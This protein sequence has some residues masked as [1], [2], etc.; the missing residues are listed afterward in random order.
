ML[1]EANSSRSCCTP[2]VS[3]PGGS[4]WSRGHRLMLRDIWGGAGNGAPYQCGRV[5]YTF[6]LQGPCQG[7][8]TACSSSLVATHNA[9]RGELFFH[10]IFNYMNRTRQCKA[11]QCAHLVGKNRQVCC[12]VM[13]AS[14]C[15]SGTS[16]D[17]CN[18]SM[19]T[20]CALNCN[21]LSLLS[22]WFLRALE[23]DSEHAHEIPP[24]EHMTYPMAPGTMR[25]CSTSAC[26]LLILRQNFRIS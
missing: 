4:M 7:I 26:S 23:R 22:G 17:P 5:A 19:A 12:T 2:S 6:G 10:R 16:K 21:A 25:L 1:L 18:H 24:Q 3:G 13:S 9:F 14:L 15:Q 8:D 11:L 20:L